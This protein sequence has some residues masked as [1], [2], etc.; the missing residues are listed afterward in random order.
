MKNILLFTFGI[1]FMSLNAQ[2]TGR[3]NPNLEYPSGSQNSSSTTSSKSTLTEEEKQ[4]LIEQINQVAQEQSEQQE[5]KHTKS[6]QNRWVVGGNLGASFGNYTNVVIGPSI[7]YRFN[8]YV[9]GGVNLGYTYT[10]SKSNWRNSMFNGGLF[11]QPTYNNF[12]G[13]INWNYYTGTRTILYTTPNIKDDINEHALWLGAGYRA[14]LGG[15]VY[16]TIGVQ[17]NVLYDKN[18]QVFGSGW[19]PIIGITAGF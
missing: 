18:S 2:Q 19:Q 9:I 16:T 17:Y 10:E 15:N 4:K 3:Q 7:G 13:M 14:Q 5:K 1:C 6:G 11:L 8:D 12:F